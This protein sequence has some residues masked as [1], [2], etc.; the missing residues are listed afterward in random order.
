MPTNGLGHFWK[1]VFTS[2]L[3]GSLKFRV[4]SVLKDAKWLG[5]CD[6]C[7]PVDFCGLLGEN[8]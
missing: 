7:L 8:E 3:N 1:F 2:P 6:I 4:F 5:A